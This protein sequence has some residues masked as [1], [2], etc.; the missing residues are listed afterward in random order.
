MGD[1]CL[2]GSA[3][4]PAPGDPEDPLSWDGLWVKCKGSAQLAPVSGPTSRDIFGA[5]GTNPSLSK[6][7]R[8]R[9]EIGSKSLRNRF[10]IGSKSVRNRFKIGSKSVQNQFEI[11]SGVR[12]RFE[13]RFE[14]SSKSVRNRLEI[15]KS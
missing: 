8:N 13:V 4:G 12:N 10:Q 6:S 3:T 14:I 15:S 5:S 9:F 1:T 11:G 7:V 2:V